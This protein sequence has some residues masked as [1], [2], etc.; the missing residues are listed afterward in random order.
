[1]RGKL[2]KVLALALALAAGQAARAGMIPVSVSVQPDGDKFRWT[3]GVI[4][5]TD[6]NINP[7]DKFT[8][9]DIGGFNAGTVVAPDGWSVS[10]SLSTPPPPGVQPNDNP[11][12]MDLT[13]INFP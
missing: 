4:V 9:Y 1:M 7:G 10:Q 2:G 8:I 6:V 11:T 3:Y 12:L 5:T 13:F